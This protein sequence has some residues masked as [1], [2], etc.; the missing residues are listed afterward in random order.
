MQLKDAAPQA[1]SYFRGAP[2]VQVWV[3]TKDGEH[4]CPAGLEP[5]NGEG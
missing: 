4:R 1:T 3:C 2:I 5:K